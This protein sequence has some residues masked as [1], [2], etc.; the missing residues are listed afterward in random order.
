[1]RFTF[2]KPS[3]DRKDRKASGWALKIAPTPITDI[4]HYSHPLITRN[5]K[6]A[7]KITKQQ[8]V[9]FAACCNLIRLKMHIIYQNERE[10]QTGK[11][12]GYMAYMAHVT[13]HGLC[14]P[15]SDTN[16]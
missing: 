10:G 9:T 6:T 5:R 7:A 12:S 2:L 11:W 1:M 8:P 4:L 14:L 13:R 3:L 16:V 15:V